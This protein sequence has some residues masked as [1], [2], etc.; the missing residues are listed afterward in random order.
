[1]TISISL[2]VCNLQVFLH[3]STLHQSLVNI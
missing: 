3:L 1:M 2:V